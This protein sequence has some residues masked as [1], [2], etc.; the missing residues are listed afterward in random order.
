ME[1]L[2][3]VTEGNMYRIKEVSNVK[4]FH[5]YIP[6][7]VICVHVTDIPITNTPWARDGK[8]YFRSSD[9]KKETNSLPFSPEAIHID[10][11][12]VEVGEVVQ[13][14]ANRGVLRGQRGGSPRPLISVF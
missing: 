9:Y 10:L 13:T 4:I 2:K 6:T 3:D 7:S 11:A 8:S 1:I 14:F 5:R 12:T